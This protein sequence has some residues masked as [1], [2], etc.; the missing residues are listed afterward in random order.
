MPVQFVQRNG[1]LIASG[2]VNCKHN[3]V[4]HITNHKVKINMLL[5]VKT[6]NLFY[7]KYMHSPSRASNDTVSDKFY[8]PK[9]LL[10][11]TRTVTV[12]VKSEHRDVLLNH[13][14][15]TT[16]LMYL[17]T[18]SKHTHT[19]THAHTHLSSISLKKP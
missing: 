10:R 7:Y 15:M 16:I 18:P 1:Q 5:R 13:S 19:D 12:Q 14:N 3:R 6:W 11:V 8:S 9:H 2:I 4:F 17:L